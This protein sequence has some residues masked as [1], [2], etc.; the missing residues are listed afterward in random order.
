MLLRF[1]LTL[2]LF[3]RATAAVRAKT[4][5]SPYYPKNY[6]RRTIK[7]PTVE[8]R[9]RNDDQNVY[10]THA[11][12]LPHLYSVPAPASGSSS[13]LDRLSINKMLKMEGPCARHKSSSEYEP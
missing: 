6:Y 9:P 2:L 8:Q 13:R 7:E 10:Q 4:S 5:P 1:Q 3:A 11:Q 12:R